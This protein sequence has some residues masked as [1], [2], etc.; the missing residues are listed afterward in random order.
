MISDSLLA[1][2]QSQAAIWYNRNGPKAAASSHGPK[3]HHNE[4]LHQQVKS[5]KGLSP[6]T[7]AQMDLDKMCMEI[8]HIVRFD[9]DGNIEQ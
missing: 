5:P 2:L 3:G 4:V 9:H 6:M 1:A 8:D 7:A